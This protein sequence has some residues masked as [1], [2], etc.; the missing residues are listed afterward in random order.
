MAKQNTTRRK[1]A[2]TQFKHAVVHVDKATELIK[3]MKL[4]AKRYG[5]P[6]LSVSALTR[7]IIQ[8]WI[9]AAPDRADS[10]R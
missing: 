1:S 4:S 3:A 9:D 8:S 10:G 7:Y 6:P 2:G 5:L